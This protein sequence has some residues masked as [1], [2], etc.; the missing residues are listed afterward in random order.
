[1]VLS[2]GS[3]AGAKFLVSIGIYINN[4]P[5][6]SS[7][8]ISA[9][10]R[11]QRLRAEMVG[12]CIKGAVHKGGLMTSFRSVVVSAGFTALILSLYVAYAYGHGG[13]AIWT[14]RHD[15]PYSAL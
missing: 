2:H 5:G 3:H 1:M 9:T 12:D 13:G 4:P 10:G 15:V 7:E 14:R 11:I 8:G 6:H